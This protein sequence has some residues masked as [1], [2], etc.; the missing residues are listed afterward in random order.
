MSRQEYIETLKK[1]IKS[2]IVSLEKYGEP[3]WDVYSKDAWEDLLWVLRQVEKN[4]AEEKE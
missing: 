1:D 4:T 2:Q 3:S